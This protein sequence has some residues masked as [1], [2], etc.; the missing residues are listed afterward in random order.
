MIRGLI[1]CFSSSS[2]GFIT[3]ALFEY[4]GRFGVEVR[5]ILFWGVVVLFTLIAFFWVL[6]PLLKLAKLKEGINEDQAAKIIGKHFPDT[7]PKY[8]GVDSKILLKNVKDPRIEIILR[9]IF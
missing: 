5:T 4:Y 6:T 3:L 7:D 1:L 8:K 9:N 2:L